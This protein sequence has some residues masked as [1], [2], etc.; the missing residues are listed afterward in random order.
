MSIY[1]AQ[2]QVTDRNAGVAAT[3]PPAWD[4]HPEADRARGLPRHLVTGWVRRLGG[5]WGM[6]ISNTMEVTRRVRCRRP[7][8]SLRHVRQPHRTAMTE[9][10]ELGLVVRGDGDV[11]PRKAN[12]FLIDTHILRRIG[13]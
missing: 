3:A 1:L 8:D 12:H 13:S 11:P 6:I 10:M 2:L 9:N 5:L 4:G 7:P